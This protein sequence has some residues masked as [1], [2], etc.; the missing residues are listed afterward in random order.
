MC[1]EI[2]RCRSSPHFSSLIGAE[3]SFKMFA[4]A[5]V[6]LSLLGHFG[7]V[8][9]SAAAEEAFGSINSITSPGQHLV[10]GASVRS[11]FNTLEKRVQ[12][13]AVSCE[14]VSF[15]RRPRQRRSSP[16]ANSRC[17]RKKGSRSRRGYAIN[18]RVDLEINES[19]ITLSYF[20][21]LYLLNMC[22]KCLAHCHRVSPVEF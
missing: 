10:A 4:S 6:L 18:L 14:K 12:C 13:G 7:S 8:C 2:H 16:A 1:V 21:I 22:L 17:R 5:L 19:G 15:I 9:G 3:G 11:L 20:I